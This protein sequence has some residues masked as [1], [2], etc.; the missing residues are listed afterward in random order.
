MQY[1]HY[2]MPLGSREAEVYEGIQFLGSDCTDKET[3][4]VV[5]SFRLKDDKHEL[6]LHVPVDDA[7][8]LLHDL[9]DSIKYTRRSRNDE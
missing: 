7:E 1:K 8:Q 5:I 3:G 2:T 6:E 4:Y 9:P